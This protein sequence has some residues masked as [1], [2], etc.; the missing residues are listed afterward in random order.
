MQ[1]QDALQTI[2]EA[3]YRLK[4]FG[5]LSSIGSYDMT[6]T[7]PKGAAKRRAELLSFVR[8]ESRKTLLDPKTL[9][10]VDTLAAHEDELSPEMKGELRLYRR[11]IDAVTGLPESLL[12][13]QSA[14]QSATEQ[15]WIENKYTGNYAAVKDGMREMIEL[16]KEADGIRASRSGGKTPAHPL[17]PVID[18]TDP[19]MTVAKL[20]PLFDEIRARTVPLLRRIAAAGWQPDCAFTKGGYDVSAQRAVTL[21]LL[22]AV[23]YNPRYGVVGAGEHPCTYGV[24]RYDVRFTDHFYPDD[25]L[26]GAIS[27]MHEGGHGMYEQNVS[28]DYL[29]LLIGGGSHGGMHESSSR[30]WENMVGRS[31]TFWDYA[32]P[33]FKGA[34]PGRLAEVPA[35]DFFLAVNRVQPSLVRIYADELTYNLHIMMRFEIEKMLFDGTLPMDSLED[36]WNEKSRDYLGIVPE[37]PWEGW[38]QD[39]HWPAGM[40]GYFQS[41][42]IG[43]LNAAQI[44]AAVK[45]ALPGFDSLV[46]AGDFTPIRQWLAEHWYRYGMLYDND[47]L[48]QK[49]T[50]EPLSA[51]YLCDYLEGK[52]S[53]IYGV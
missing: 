39:M 28:E 4:K 38:A 37:K 36:A 17:D 30:F 33:L 24:N 29:D 35:R 20:E 10:A 31:E 13:R 14:L 18:S 7:A 47:T 6:A 45:K 34:F 41:Y 26:Q 32:A 15:L 23:G 12:Q 52:F 51:G 44:G 42:T 8:A 53:A 43:T 1:L 11:R 25:L 46:R 16:Q 27:A 2:R 22:E 21:K 3:S 49:I 50:G 5:E 9:A 19:G 40:F 48:L